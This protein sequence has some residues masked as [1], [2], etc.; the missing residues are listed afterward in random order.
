MVAGRS[1]AVAPA[2]LR[3]SRPSA[4]KHE[5]CQHPGRTSIHTREK[6]RRRADASAAGMLSL[7]SRAGSASQVSPALAIVALRRRYSAI[8]NQ[9]GRLFRAAG[10]CRRFAARLHRR[11]VGCKACGFRPGGTYASVHRTAIPTRWSVRPT[12]W[13]DS[14]RES[15]SRETWAETSTTR[16]PTSSCNRWPISP[17]AAGRCSWS[18]TRISAALRTART[19]SPEWSPASL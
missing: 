2:G 11:A 17:A 10:R 6:K 3:R 13:S 16:T 19:H 9:P 7:P 8:T 12:G 18:P 1:T 4:T 15:P 14:T 5:L